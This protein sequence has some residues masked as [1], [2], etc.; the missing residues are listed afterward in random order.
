MIDTKFKLYA[1]RDK[2]SG[3]FVTNLTNPRQKF[4]EKKGACENAVEKYKQICRGRL[5]IPYN[6]E[7]LEIVELFCFEK[8]NEDLQYE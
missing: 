1:V 6:P 3:T 8:S 2:K 4:W 5:N 7:D